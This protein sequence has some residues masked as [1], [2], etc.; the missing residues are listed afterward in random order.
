MMGF[1]IAVLVWCFALGA[2]VGSFLNV[3]AWRLPLG[4]SLS[5]PAS[6]CPQCK[7]PIRYRDNVP[8]IGWLA[9]RGRCRAC[10]TQISARYP[11]VEFM[12]GAAF[13]GIAWCE[14]LI[15]WSVPVSEGELSGSFVELDFLVVN[16]LYHAALAAILIVLALFEFD[17]ARVPRR[18]ALTA[19]AMGLLLPVALGKL[20]TIPW[21]GE[22]PMTSEAWTIALADHA[23]GAACGALLAG[24][25]V[26]CLQGLRGLFRLGTEPAA[27]A[28]IATGTFLGWRAVIIVAASVAGLLL[29]VAVLGLL[30]KR[31]APLRPAL[32]TALAAIA[33]V[34][35]WPW[36]P[37][38][39]RLTPETDGTGA[40]PSVILL[41]GA[42]LALAAVVRWSRN[43]TA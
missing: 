24:L 9:L 38:L 3:V 11:L 14:L 40:L 2:C 41:L 32:F 35:A 42:S 37:L 33:Y 4:M 10:G 6:H 15:G 27:V 7:T 1:E 28:L 31:R 21:G 17:A 30:R 36:A 23:P 34:V 5:Y 13:A 29:L 8:V 22:G 18:F 26:C 39:A 16:W 19:L 25:F 20:P 43:I 12:T